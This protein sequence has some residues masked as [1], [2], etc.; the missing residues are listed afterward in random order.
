MYMSD[1]PDNTVPY[2]DDGPP[3]GATWN[4]HVDAS[5]RQAYGWDK[6]GCE[7]VLVAAHAAGGFPATRLRIPA[8][9]GP[10]DTTY[11][12]LRIHK[13]LQS[14]HPL[15]ATNPI[16][17]YCACYSLDVVAAVRAAIAAGSKTFGE[18]YHI[19]QDPPTTLPQVVDAMAAGSQRCARASPAYPLGLLKLL[20]KQQSAQAACA[21]AA[22][23]HSRSASGCSRRRHRPSSARRRR[24]SASLGT[25]STPPCTAGTASQRRSVISVKLL[26]SS[27]LPPF[28]LVFCAQVLKRL[29]RAGWKPT[30]MQEWYKETVAFFDGEEGEEYAAGDSL[31]DSSAPFTD[32]ELMAKLDKI[33]SAEN[34]AKI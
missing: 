18:A 27:C 7:E 22:T 34:S 6:R 32:E 13:W 26:L 31:D 21:C 25:S 33:W 24:P 10:G 4:A 12:W 8:I 17:G 19:T 20:H 16:G 14:G 28:A 2:D 30:P 29:F 3:S 15:Y 23:L 5:L 1:I 11:R 9:C